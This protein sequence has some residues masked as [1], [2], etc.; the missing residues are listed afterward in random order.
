MDR[1]YENN[2]MIKNWIKKVCNKAI[3]IWKSV[4]K[5]LK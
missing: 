4:K 5:T 1:I 3:N 2:I